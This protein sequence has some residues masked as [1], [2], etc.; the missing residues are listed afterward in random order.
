[1]KG[2]NP[3]AS[4]A[5]AAKH[6]DLSE[7]RFR[8]MLDQDIFKRRPRGDYNLDVIR[9]A[10]IRNLRAAAEGR[11]DGSANLTDQRTRLTKATAD[12]AERRAAL[13]AGKLVDI[14][15]MVKLQSIEN[16]VVRER[17]LSASGELQGSIGVE[18]AEIVDS[19]LCEILTELSDANSIK[20]R[21]AYRKAGLIDLHN[22]AIAA[23]KDNDN[24]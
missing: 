8:E 12:R 5:Q 7:R 16:S 1:M 21:A 13:D 4:A 11:A 23:N 9:I 14:D 15:D 19:K 3:M 24:A 2:E 18:N 10:Y 20:R 6:I 17:L 22:E